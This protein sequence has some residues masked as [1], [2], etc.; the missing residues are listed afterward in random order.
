MASIGMCVSIAK[1]SN[2]EHSFARDR[3][4]NNMCRVRCSHIVHEAHK[5]ISGTHSD[6]LKASYQM[7]NPRH[8]VLLHK[9][10]LEE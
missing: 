9:A 4:S 6:A 1:F 5:K 10:I 7:T 8:F 2:S 3:S